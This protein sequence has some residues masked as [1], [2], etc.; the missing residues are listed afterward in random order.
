M[1][2]VAASVTIH[3]LV[4]PMRCSQTFARRSCH[5]LLNSVSCRKTQEADKLACADAHELLHRGRVP[6]VAVSVGRAALLGMAICANGVGQAAS[7]GADYGVFQEPG[8]SASSVQCPLRCGSGVWWR[9]APDRRTG[10]TADG[11]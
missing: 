4:A 8:H 6:A 2:A 7:F 9:T 1:K 10:F 5:E 11:L 3:G